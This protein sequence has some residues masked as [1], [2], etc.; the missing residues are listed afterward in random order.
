MVWR[1]SLKVTWSKRGEI[2]GIRPPLTRDMVERHQQP[3]VP[4]RIRLDTCDPPHPA[5]I[6]AFPSQDGSNSNSVHIIDR[7]R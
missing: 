2:V 6:G 4:A 5:Q 3:E 1:A 7:R